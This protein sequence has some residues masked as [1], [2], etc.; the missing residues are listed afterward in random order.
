MVEHI[1]GGASKRV[2]TLIYLVSLS[3]GVTYLAIYHFGQYKHTKPELI[4]GKSSTFLN[5]LS[6]W[7]Y[8]GCHKRLLKRKLKLNRREGGPQ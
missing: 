2:H 3:H 4:I 6:E 7:F 8:G 5:H 1:Y